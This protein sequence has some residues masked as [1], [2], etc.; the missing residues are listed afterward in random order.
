MNY[1]PILLDIRNRTAIVFGGGNVAERKCLSL[2][3]AG[4]RVRV[5]SPESVPGIA[6]LASEGR[7]EH[8]RREYRQ[9]DVSDAFLVFAATGRQK[10]NQAIAEEATLRGI[11]VNIADCP[12]MS[13][14]V[15]PAVVA[16]G[17]LLITVSTGGKSPALAGK[18]RQ[19]LEDCFGIEYDKALRLL[20]AVR[21]KLLTVNQG[22]QYNKKLFNRFVS[23]DLPGLVKNKSFDEIDHLLRDIFGPDF[24]LDKL[25]Q[26]IKDP[27]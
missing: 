3:R 13:T 19:E 7:L 27:A 16:R 25:G 15:S 11:P 9:G 26:E 10:V 8:L 6:T 5:V 18:I 4:A 22:S 2:L 20:G 21:E 17:D 23:H 12:E 24:T 14:F 1:F